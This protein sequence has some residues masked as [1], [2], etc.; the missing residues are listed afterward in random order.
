VIKCTEIRA[1]ENIADVG[2]ITNAY[3]ILVRIPE[4][5]YICRKMGTLVV[6]WILKK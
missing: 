1:V 2:V 6:R 5:R 3:K 4:G